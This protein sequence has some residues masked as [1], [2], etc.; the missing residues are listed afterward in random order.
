VVPCS[1]LEGNTETVGQL[2]QALEEQP[3]EQLWLSEEV[4]PLALHR[5]TWPLLQNFCPWEHLSATHLPPEQCW[6]DAHWLSD[7]H[8]L[9]QVP[10]EQL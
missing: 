4:E 9:G 2:L 3:H 10:P 8:W 6:A 5:W 7:W 1:P